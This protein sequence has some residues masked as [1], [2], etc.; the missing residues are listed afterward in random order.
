MLDIHIGITDAA[1]AQ[2]ALASIDGVEGV[3]IHQ[4]TDAGNMYE[5][6]KRG[7]AMGQSPRVS[8]LDQDDEIVLPQNLKSMLAFDSGRPYFTN[9]EV[10]MA[11]SKRRLYPREFKWEGDKSFID[12]YAPHQLMVI[13]REV[14]LEAV[15]AAYT[16][17]LSSDTR[18]LNCAELAISCEI[19][20]KVGWTYRASLAYRWYNNRADSMHRRDNG[21]VE[22][23]QYYKDLLLRKSV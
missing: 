18:F 11:G 1:I 4:I 9:S 7:Y 6:R 5:L 3:H 21:Y 10:I 16:R 2:R 20:L 19:Q 14:A 23:F 17:I 13:P 15:D 8:F 12:G 22:V